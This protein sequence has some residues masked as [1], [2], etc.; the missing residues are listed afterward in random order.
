MGFTH[1]ARLQQQLVS[2]RRTQFSAKTDATKEHRAV[3]GSTSNDTTSKETFN[4]LYVARN[5]ER[6][7]DKTK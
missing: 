3:G 5:N 7:L 1:R 6:G 2:R 4:K